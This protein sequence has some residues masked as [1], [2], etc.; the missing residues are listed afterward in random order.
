MT[1]S[2]QGIFSHGWIG[3]LAVMYP[4][5]GWGSLLRAIMEISAPAISL[6]DRAQRAIR[7]T[8]ARRRR[9]DRSSISSH[10]LADLGGKSGYVSVAP[11]CA[12]R[13][14]RQGGRLGN[15]GCLEAAAMGE[16]APCDARQLVGKRDRQHIAV[17]PL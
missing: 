16:N 17:Q 14:S 10:P 2:W 13:S 5:S 6:A 4:A 1:P 15:L 7:V 11:S 12:D 9:E 3:G 8:S